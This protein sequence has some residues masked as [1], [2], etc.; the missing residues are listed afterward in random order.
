ML[1]LAMLTISN[2]SREN[3]RF[4]ARGHDIYLL[5]YSFFLCAPLSH[6]FILSAI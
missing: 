6:S 3:A 4:R 1:D 2:R 5:L